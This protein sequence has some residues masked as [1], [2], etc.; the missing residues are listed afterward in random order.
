MSSQPQKGTERLRGWR[1]IPRN[2]GHPAC[3]WQ[4]LLPANLVVLGLTGP[5]KH[6]YNLSP[7]KQPTRFKEGLVLSSGFQGSPEWLSEFRCENSLSKQCS[8]DIG[9]MRMGEKSGAVGHCRS[10]G[11]FSLKL[12]GKP[13]S[14]SRLPFSY[15]GPWPPYSLTRTLFCHVPGT[16]PPV[17]LFLL[18]TS[19]GA[20]EMTLTE[21][22]TKHGLKTG[23]LIP[24]GST[25]PSSVLYRLL[26]TDCECTQI[27]EGLTFGWD[28]HTCKQTAHGQHSHKINMH[29]NRQLMDA[30]LLRT[31]LLQFILIPVLKLICPLGTAW[32][33][34]V[35][36]S[37]TCYGQFL[38]WE[39]SLR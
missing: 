3:P 38:L 33:W 6:C 14:R 21:F 28:K 39:T 5:G 13:F 9:C 4:R 16:Y 8:T 27:G 34:F 31:F 7:S 15:L 23:L 1:C 22:S 25:A 36:L 32:F 37:L 29:V 26:Y 30:S 19:P 20:A 35:F 12:R 10:S 24:R 2:M 11:K 18:T 17:H